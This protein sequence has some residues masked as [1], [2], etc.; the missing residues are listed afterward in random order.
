MR[1][2]SDVYRRTLYVDGTKP[3]CVSAWDIDGAPEITDAGPFARARAENRTS[4]FSHHHPRAIFLP[5]SSISMGALKRARNASHSRPRSKAFEIQRLPVELLLEVFDMVASVPISRSGHRRNV[6]AEAPYNLMHTCRYWRDLVLAQPHLFSNVHAP[7]IL[8]DARIGNKFLRFLRNSI[9]RAGSH[10]ISIFLEIDAGKLNSKRSIQWHVLDQLLSVSTRWENVYIY[11]G[12]V[13]QNHVLRPLLPGALAN[14]TSLYLADQSGP[15]FLPLF[16]EAVRSSGSLRRLSIRL[17]PDLL[18]HI[19][20]AQLTHLRLLSIHGDVDISELLK[21]FSNCVELTSLEISACDAEPLQPEGPVLPISIP[22]LSYLEIGQVLHV[23][24]LVD[25]VSLIRSPVLRVLKVSTS[26]EEA[27]DVAESLEDDDD[28]DEDDEDE[29]DEDED[30][31]DDDEEYDGEDWDEDDLDQDLS[32]N[33]GSFL[34][35]CAGTLK[36][37]HLSGHL[38]VEL[39]LRALEIFRDTTIY[40]NNLRWNVST[41]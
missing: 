21:F 40:V 22:A 1:V 17:E 14:L 34:Y 13:L 30:D 32:A 31:E 33:I 2:P 26:D 23:E 4:P 25:L 41:L 29:D 18:D 5:S 10:P 16:S 11:A 36:D 7:L 19:P 8:E 27:P 24:C 20:W 6:L 3:R 28:E 35:A 38:G 9:R 12:D 39:A 37:L 15:I